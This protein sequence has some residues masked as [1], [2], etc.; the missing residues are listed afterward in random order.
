[1]DTNVQE[2]NYWL[3][4]TNHFIFQLSIVYRNDKIDH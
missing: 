2:I 1:M 4:G 3:D